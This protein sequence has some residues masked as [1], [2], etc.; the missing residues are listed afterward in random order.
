M[1]PQYFEDRHARVF[2]PR[3]APEKAAQERLEEKMREVTRVMR[4]MQ[5]RS[6]AVLRGIGSRGSV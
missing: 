4:E 5:R 1:T 6:D 2:R 3:V